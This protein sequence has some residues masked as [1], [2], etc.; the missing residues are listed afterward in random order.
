MKMSPIQINVT[1]TNVGYDILYICYLFECHLISIAYNCITV[2]YKKWCSKVSH[3]Q[4]N[5]TYR[6]VAY[7]IQ[8]TLE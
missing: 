4:M 1:Y 6:N 7:D 5:V 2:T 8:K 3:F